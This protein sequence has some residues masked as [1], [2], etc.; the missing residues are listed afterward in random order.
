[1]QKGPFYGEQTNQLVVGDKLIL[2]TTGIN[3]RLLF[4]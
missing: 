1:M 2:K 4:S 3:L